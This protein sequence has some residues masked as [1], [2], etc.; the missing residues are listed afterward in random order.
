MK[1]TGLYIAI[2]ISALL[3]G[4][5]CSASIQAQTTP[6]PFEGLVGYPRTYKLDA[7][8][9]SLAEANFADPASFASFT[10]NPAILGF[11]HSSR[12]IYMSG[13]QN[14]Q[15]NLNQFD[16]SL[17]SVTLGRHSGL[18]RFGY[19][20]P[21][22]GDINPLG[23]SDQP[24]PDLALYQIEFTYAF[25]VRSNFSVGIA[26]TL[27]YGNNDDAQFTT[28]MV[29]AGLIYDPDGAISYAMV[30][31]GIGRGLKYEFIEDGTTILGSRSIPVS[32]QIGASF[33]FPVDDDEPYLT[34]S[35]AN[36][37]RFGESGLWYKGGLEI[38]PA[39][40]LSLRSGLMFQPED[41]TYVPRYGIGFETSFLEF[42]YALSPNEF[43]DERY[44]TIGITIHF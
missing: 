18:L 38:K 26:Q 12:S 1:A 14:W 40:F 36:E 34:L 11:T 20:Y 31:N 21:G 42:D 8:S 19:F 35:F 5:L 13:F 23:S 10:V 44:H 24:E 16:L 28:Y 4:L 32:L 30:L 3:L 9:V 39:S 37:K 7:R 33:R 2:W 43:Q 29:N 41:L 6:F 15:N 27:S 25:F 22:L 17:P